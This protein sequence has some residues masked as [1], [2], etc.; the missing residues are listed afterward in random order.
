MG[1]GTGEAVGR[2]KSYILKGIL[3]PSDKQANMALCACTVRKN[4]LKTHI[5]NAY[6]C[7]ILF[8]IKYC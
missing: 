2:N 8:I 6:F 1:G 5:N 7:A 4:S 3:W